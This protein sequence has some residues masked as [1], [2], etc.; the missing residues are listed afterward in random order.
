MTSS[1]SLCVVIAMIIIS[2]LT[3]SISSS[4][5]IEENPHSFQSVQSTHEVW[6][7]LHNP[8][9]SRYQIPESS[10]I[11]HS[12]F[13]SFDPKSEEIPLGPWQISGLENPLDQRLHVVQSVSG[14]LQSLE[15]ALSGLGIGIID[16]I[17]DDSVVIAL[18][19]RNSAE[20]IKQIQDLSQ[21]RWI[22]PMPSM[23]KI[24]PSLLPTML[25]KHAILDLDVIPSPINSEEE[26][27]RLEME[28]S[29]NDG[30]SQHSS[31]CDIRLCQIKLS[32]ATIIP[33]LALDHRVLKIEPGQVLS[34]QN[35]NAS[36]ISGID[37]AR[38]IYTSNLTGEGEVLGITDTGLDSD[39]GDF[40]GRLRSPVY[41][42]FGPDNSGAD[43]NSGHGTHV[44]ATLLGDGSGDENATG[45]V[46][47][48]TFHFYQLEVDSS[49]ILARWGSLYDM[50][51]HSHL[52]DA[53]IHTNSWGSTSLVGDYT[54]DARSA[55]WFSN[56]Y[57][58]F[59][60]I[61]SV[62]DMAQSGVTS[63]STAKNV[64][65]VGASTT[66]AFGS[67]PLGSVT[68]NS[69]VGPTSDGRIKPE[70]VAPGVMICSARAEEASLATGG[71][72]SDSTHD[73]ST[74]PLYMTMS[75]SSMA[76]PV[77][78]GASAMARQFLREEAGIQTPRSDL[79]RA[80]LVN[81]ADD[82]GE[83]DVPN[84]IEGWGQLNL[85]NSLFPQ[86]E[87]GNLTVFYDQDRQL[88]PGHS[89]IYTFEVSGDSGLE[90]TL[91]WNDREG[92]S[93]SDQNASRLVNDLDLILTSPG[94]TEYFGNNFANGVSQSGGSRDQLNNL[95]RIRIPSGEAGTW[96][97]QIG[98]SGGFAQ[99]FS[100]VLSAD[101]VERQESDLSVV[102]NSIFTSDTSPLK[103]ETISIQ[104][105]WINQAAAATGDYSIRLQDTS[106]DSEIGTYTM[107]SLPGGAVETF[108]I[109]HSFQ[110]TGEHLV[111]LTL[112]YLSEVE[113]LNDENSGSNNNVFE[114]LFEVT[115]IGVRLTPLMED[116]S[117]P[118]DF[119]EAQSAKH[120]DL[121]PSTQSWATFQL[122]LLNEGTSEITVELV[123]TAVQ[124]MDESGVLDTPQDEWSKTLNETSPWVLSP[125]GQTGDRVIVT[126]NLTD[127]DA[128]TD[129]RYALPGLFVTDLILYDKMAPTVSHSVRLSVGVDRVEGLYT[130]PAGTQGLGAK[131]DNFALFTISVR[132][133]GNG[134]TEYSISCESEDRW[135]IR[136]GSSQSSEAT[137]GPLS[138]LQFVPV[139]IRVKVPP[140]SS[141]L[142][143]G[144]TNLVT[145]VTTSV[146]DPSLQT[147]ETA[148]AEVFESRDFSTQILDSEG[149]ELGPL[150]ISQ[151]RAVLNGDTVSTTLSL[152]NLGNVPLV[153]EI[154]A[155]SSSNTW[156]IQIFMSGEAPPAGEVTSIQT[157][158]SRGDVANFTILT[159]VPLASE[160]GDKNTISI[161]TTLD[162]NTVTNGTLLEVKEITTLEIESDS[163]FSVALGRSAN[164]DIHLHN[165]GNVPLAID[166]TLG[167]LP[168]GWS[169]GFLTGK[170]FS[171]D[172]NRESVITVG[173]ELPSGIPA[174]TQSQTVPVIIE[175]TSPSM[176]NEVLTVELQ[177][178]VI[179]SVWIE[180]QSSVSRLQGIPENEESVLTLQVTN[181]GNIPSGVSL[182][183]EAPEGWSAEIDPSILGELDV[184]ESAEVTVTVRPS[185]AS[186]D[187]L[188]QLTINASS[189]L[190]QQG[191]TTTSSAITIDVSKIKSSNQGGIS[192]LFQTLGLP[193]W[194]LALVFI[195][196]L[197][198]LVT[199]GIR[200]RNE[201]A[202]LGAEEELIPRGSALLAG[203]KEERKAAALETSTSGDVVTGDV[204]DSEIED[205]IQSTIPTLPTHQVPEG[206]LPLPLT[207]L[208][209][210]WT[211]EQWVA[212]G[213]IWWEQNGP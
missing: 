131:P 187:G 154:R 124:I 133:I 24:S 77:V 146:N 86:S 30:V 6:N 95:E 137:I 63:P 125:N 50:F 121:D 212:Y 29:E 174:G 171:M 190:E 37:Y 4:F 194:S 42:L 119:Q 66:G 32:D 59:L 55:D 96:T 68:G 172:M 38:S 3:F 90:A 14:D 27:T 53:Y 23:W 199:V 184:G 175:S 11:I 81:G 8:V 73:S 166:L 211:M 127:E 113:E 117:H 197:A 196:A 40:D 201:L 198:G 26:N 44:A 140:T 20:S 156:P 22:G 151:S 12:P 111:K 87:V 67:E 58:E 185:A 192:G 162:G 209:E 49:G 79:I 5:S 208:P 150:A 167:T 15:D 189:T 176:T 47:E 102:P 164:S 93:S 83:K 57:P 13:G 141:G 112:D 122:E 19:S 56:D 106:D 84:N 149:E 82:I 71:P 143:S 94:G 2:P 136:V 107:P 97:I 91:A 75:G 200:A 145:C 98:H 132:N 52:N 70:L 183:P 88:L 51:E 34:I 170:T 195:F 168:Q 161:K 206:A 147:I 99:E 159:I 110:S 157:T 179:P 64:L 144:T 182:Q 178:T 60:V 105:S 123:V 163:G 148:V 85:T 165:S 54:S 188:K 210:G 45:M 116:G 46:P 204:S 28:I 153:F 128:D 108:S 152:S 18:P 31:Y 142:A 36:M 21:V 101:A 191:V 39:H 74:T 126:L 17:P 10:G 92:S 25:T 160:K 129:S 193:A 33:N 173:L 205:M 134:P 41:N 80:L 213:H 100:L 202:P 115:E 72:C 104:L 43:S 207:G 177:V 48:S 7:E 118:S 139:P 69:S 61:F 169:G 1:K 203:S 35:T 130:V 89:F 16:S 120:R 62:G 155:L 114:L 181:L 186:E 76:T 78:A 158:V 180:V 138:R 9:S 65:S 103:G 109:Y 135:I